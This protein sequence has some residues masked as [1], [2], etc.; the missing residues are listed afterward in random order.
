[1]KEIKLLKDRRRIVE[2]FD[3]Q[4]IIILFKACDLRTFVGLRDDTLMIFLLKYP[5]SS[6]H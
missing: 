6:K 1:M 2:T 5:R 3:K 4:Q